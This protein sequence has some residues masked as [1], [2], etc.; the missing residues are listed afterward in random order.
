M[1]SRVR[2]QDRWY[3]L[4]PTAWYT[5]GVTLD[6]PRSPR[7]AQRR[8]LYLADAPPR[9]PF[10][11]STPAPPTPTGWSGR[12]GGRPASPTGA[13]GGSPASGLATAPVRRSSR[14][15]SGGRRSH[16]PAATA[17]RASSS[18]SSSTGPSPTTSTSR[19][20]A[21]P[22]LAFLGRDPGVPRRRARRRSRRR[23]GSRRRARRP[24]APAR[25]PTA[26]CTTGGTSG[27][28][29]GRARPSPSCTRRGRRSDHDDGRGKRL[30]AWASTLRVRVGG[31]AS[32][33]ASP[34]R[35]CG[36]SA[37]CRRARPTR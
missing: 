28:A 27:C 15:T 30:R 17:P 2:S 23:T 21:A 16:S 19:R 7:D 9:A 1:A 22:S 13:S 3:P 35:R 10:P 31:A 32:R 37:R 24:A 36:T 14:R 26:G 12:C 29:S 25:G 34:P 20:T 8:R 11:A 6:E 4:R 5:K 33:C 18:M